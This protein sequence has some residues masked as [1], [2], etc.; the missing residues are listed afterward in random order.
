MS[1]PYAAPQGNFQ[2]N[3]P[4][5]TGPQLASRDVRF[6]GALIDGILA[7]IIAVPIVLLTTFVFAALLGES[8]LGQIVGWGINL[9]LGLLIFLAL[10]GYLLATRGKTIG[11]LVMKTTILDR[12][13]GQLVPFGPLYAK[14]YLLVSL[15]FSIPYVGGLLAI[16]DALMIFRSNHACLHDDIAGTM[17][18]KDPQ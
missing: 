6:L 18:V 11:K 3:K 5:S 16:V 1:N 8:L 10:H 13:T 15:L 17:V 7:M 12:K 4:V 9:A 14:R 2:P